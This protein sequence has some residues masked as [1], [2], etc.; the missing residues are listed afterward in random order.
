M[1]RILEKEIMDD[2]EG[3]L[4][5]AKADM[6]KSNQFFVD[7]L[8]QKYSKNLNNV[9]DIGCGP[10][11]IPIRLVKAEPDVNITAVDASDKMIELAK[12]NVK[13]EKYENNIKLMKAHLPGLPFLPHSFDTIISNSLLHHLPDPMLF[14]EE[15]KLLGKKSAII[16]VM[17]LFRPN[18]PEKAKE[19]VEREAGNAPKIHKEDFYNSLLAAFTLSEVKDQLRSAGLHNVKAEIVSDIHWLASGTIS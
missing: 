11:D 8:L 1:Q 18:S 4:A 15:I 9:L 14:W 6:S 19:I 3:A 5:Y 10:A 2:K 13:K 16:F 7:K 17:D 12:N